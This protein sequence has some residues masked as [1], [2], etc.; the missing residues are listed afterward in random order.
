M[1]YSPWGHKESDTTELLSTHTEN[2]AYKYS[3][4]NILPESPGSLPPHP[5][6]PE[7]QILWCVLMVVL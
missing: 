7:D 6:S 5:A 3:P 4:T 1:D 2:K